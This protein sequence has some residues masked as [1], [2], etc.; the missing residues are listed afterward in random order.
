MKQGRYVFKQGEPSDEYY[1]LTEGELQVIVDGHEVK[2]MTKPS[3][4]EGFGFGELSMLY[5]TPRTAS[6]L[7][8]KG[9]ANSST[10]SKWSKLKKGAKIRHNSCKLWYLKRTD[11]TKHVNLEYL[12]THS[13]I[14]RSA[15]Q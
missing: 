11:F 8:A 7:V 2:R 14:R 10:G 9:R 15:Y 13:D 6:V 5:K 4:E 1:I 12:F 3:P